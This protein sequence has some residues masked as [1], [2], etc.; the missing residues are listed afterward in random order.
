MI[1]QDKIIEIEKLISEDIKKEFNLIKSEIFFIIDQDLDLY[2]LKEFL[3]YYPPKAIRDRAEVLLETLLNYFM[4]DL[5]ELV[6]NLDPDKQYLYFKENIREQIRK[7]ATEK[8]QNLIPLSIPIYEEKNF[9]KKFPLISSVVLSSGGIATAIV[10]PESLLIKSIPAA[11]SLLASLYLLKSYKDS[12]KRLKKKWKKQI[13]TFL[14]EKREEI[15]IWLKEIQ[16]NILERINQFLLKIKENS[17]KVT[18]M[19]GL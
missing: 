16:S 11:S 6:K 4:K 7:S 18:A 2:F 15:T 5:L 14:N 17:K 8:L 13:D 10:I 1:T 12:A 19:E 9:E 3:R